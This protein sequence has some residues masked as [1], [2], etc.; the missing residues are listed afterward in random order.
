MPNTGLGKYIFRAMYTLALH[1]LRGCKKLWP[2][3]SDHG[4]VLLSLGRCFLR[5]LPQ[6]I[7]DLELWGGAPLPKL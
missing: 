6:I 2:Q 5:L 3:Y 7:R 4:T 1:L